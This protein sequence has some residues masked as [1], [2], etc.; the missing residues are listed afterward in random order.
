[1]LLALASHFQHVESA[2]PLSETLLVEDQWASRMHITWS[3]H[4]VG[5]AHQQ[6]QEL[7]HSAE[8]YGRADVR[9]IIK[10]TRY[11]DRTHSSFL[12]GFQRS[13]PPDRC[14][15]LSDKIATRRKRGGEA[16]SA[17]ACCRPNPRF[18]YEC[19]GMSFFRFPKDET[20][21]VIDFFQMFYFIYHVSCAMFIWHNSRTH[22]LSIWLFVYKVYCSSVQKTREVE[23]S[24]DNQVQP[25]DTHGC[26]T[27][28]R[29]VQIN[30][31]VNISFP[32]M[33][34]SILN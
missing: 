12:R 23:Y 10:D 19:V 1:V 17:F 24:F 11:Q 26:L 20:R 32:N 2:K 27:S 9:A 5:T 31:W 14:V 13:Q 34:P 7:A 25:S 16:C 22:S 18:K 4:D 33:F 29:S 21:Y 15:L 6:W 28:I 3:S 30:S 8:Y